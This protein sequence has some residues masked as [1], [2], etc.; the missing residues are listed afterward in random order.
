MRI[1]TRSGDKGKTSLIYGERV[2]KNDL[3]V[4]AYGTCDEANSMIGLAISFLEEKSFPKKIT[5]IQELIRVQTLLFYVGSEIATPADK[6]VPWQ[7]K[8]EHIQTLEKQIDHWDEQ[9]EPLTNFILPSGVQ[10][11]SAVHVARTVTRRAE[12]LAVAIEN[13][14]PLAI[15]FLNRLSDYLFVAARYIN[16]SLKGEERSLL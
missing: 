6:E 13:V 4:E 14:N 8:E 2:N 16:Q 10:A 15:A 7:L 3:R 9:L 11:A 1:Y 5:V 12:R